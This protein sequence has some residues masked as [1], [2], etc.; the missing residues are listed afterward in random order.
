M[1]AFLRAPCGRSKHATYCETPP[2]MEGATKKCFIIDD[3]IVFRMCL[4]EKGITSYCAENAT[5]SDATFWE[6]DQADYS[7]KHSSSREE[8]RGAEKGL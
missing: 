8:C 1:L 2:A 4:C 5:V 3:P 7:D 6:W